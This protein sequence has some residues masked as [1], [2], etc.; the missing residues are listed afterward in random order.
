MLQRGPECL[1]R[2]LRLAQPFDQ[3]LGDSIADGK[4]DES[5]R[6]ESVLAAFQ[7]ADAAER[8]ERLR[9][10]GK[11]R[12]MRRKRKMRRRMRRK[13]TMRMRTKRKMRRKMRRMRREKK[14]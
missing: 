2:R 1:V 6:E 13:R 14:E 8:R 10:K 7:E 3:L 4:I 11:I 5:A 9:R 12:R